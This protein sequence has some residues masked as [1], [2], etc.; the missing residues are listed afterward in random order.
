MR[1]VSNL[2][3]PK[4]PFETVML[5]DANQ[6][7]ALM[8]VLV[9]VLSFGFRFSVFGFGFGFSAFKIYIKCIIF[10]V[11]FNN[12]ECS[13]VAI[14]VGA[15]H[16][17]GKDMLPG[18]LPG[19]YGY[20]SDDGN[21][22]L[23][24]GQGEPYGPPFATGDVVGC[25]L[26]LDNKLYFTKNGQN[27]GTAFTLPRIKVFPIIGLDKASIS[28]NFGH[29]PFLYNPF[30]NSATPSPVEKG[31][32]TFTTMTEP[33]LLH[34]LSFLTPGNLLTFANTNKRYFQ[35]SK[36]NQIWKSLVFG[37]WETVSP[38]VP[39]PRYY[40]FFKK[41]TIK[42]AQDSSGPL[43]ENCPKWEFLCPASL[44]K[45]GRTA[46][47]KIDYCAVCE[48]H[49]YLVHNM[50]ELKAKVASKQCVAIDF[51]CLVFDQR[52]TLR[53]KFALF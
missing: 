2:E 24:N 30:T 6:N 20:H 1:V 52:N 48:K 4:C 22:F 39:I 12:M 25:G 29:S 7:Q 33:T 15:A 49:V 45:F 26:T 16:I 31:N 43:I 10:W 5:S 40:E 9:L 42:E 35:I 34:V 46:D 28:T 3:N 47:P 27:L 17:S 50:E 36:S 19:S 23:E 32:F 44:D 21:A 14:G 53:G 13:T 41:R 18:W 11:Y 51:D 37:T 8:R 38:T